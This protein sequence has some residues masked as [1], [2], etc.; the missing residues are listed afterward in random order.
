MVWVWY[1]D[2]KSRYAET[3]NKNKKIYIAGIPANSA[4]EAVDMATVTCV[5][6]NMWCMGWRIRLWCRRWIQTR[7]RSSLSRHRYL[8]KKIFILFVC[9]H[10]ENTNG[11]KVGN[12]QEWYVVCVTTTGV[13]RPNW[14][15]YRGEKKMFPTRI[16]ECSAP[17]EKLLTKRP[18]AKYG[19][20]L[21][22]ISFPFVQSA[23]DLDNEIGY[24][25]IIMNGGV[26]VTTLSMPCF[27][28]QSLQHPE[29][30]APLLRRDS[31][32]P[33]RHIVI[34]YLDQRRHTHTHT[35]TQS[36][37]TVILYLCIK[38]WSSTNIV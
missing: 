34:D 1:G 8:H 7:Y 2:G 30:A 38:R 4:R 19:T 6:Y 15:L 25:A 16:C 26:M 11:N 14:S 32:C 13:C 31:S 9:T 24:C 29:L 20:F 12:G 33:A 10:N 21:F 3:K 23:R 28:F 17:N 22:F 35:R 27:S 18:A 37:S 5:W 36:L